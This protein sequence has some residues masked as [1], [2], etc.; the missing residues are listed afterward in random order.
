MS[1]YHVG[2]LGILVV[3]VAACVLARDGCAEPQA[4]VQ[5]ETDVEYGTAGG[6]KLLLDVYRPG[7][8]APGG[9]LRPA[10]MLVHGGGWAGG[11][12][13]QFRD[14][15]M[16]LAGQGYVCF[17]VGYRLVKPDANRHPAQLDDVQR[18]VRW[19]RAHAA[20]YGVDPERVGAMGGSAGGHLVA[21]LG[22]RD[23]RDNSDPALAAYSSRVCCV[24]DLFGP[25]DLTRDFPVMGGGLPVRALVSGLVGKP[26]GEARE[27]Y[28]DA[29]PLFF[30]DKKT[31]PFL[32]V[33]GT[34]DPIVPLEQSQLLH[35]ALR[36][37]GIESTLLKLEGEGH[38][39]KKKENTDRMLLTT[40]EFL[41]KHLKP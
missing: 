1:R 23:T 20:K 2:W 7:G 11:N 5:V 4:G 34:E 21:L 29:S 28:R 32:I 22:T 30:V 15:G 40:V 12:K 8:E 36:K 13:G 39:F 41:E 16:G 14:A 35:D 10:I 9:K 18:A 31:V 33:H 3:L 6:Q 38:G 25:T 27:A 17:S 37:A 24:V 19:V 26:I